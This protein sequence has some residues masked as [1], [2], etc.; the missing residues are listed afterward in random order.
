VLTQHGL[1]PLAEEED[2]TEYRDWLTLKARAAVMNAMEE[3]PPATREAMRQ[4]YLAMWELERRVKSLE[5][6]IQ[7]R[8]GSLGWMRRLRTIPAWV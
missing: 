3:L 6:A 5:T 4:E 7:A 2:E 1:K 8:A